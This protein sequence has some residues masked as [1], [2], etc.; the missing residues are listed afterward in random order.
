MGESTDDQN[1]VANLEPAHLAVF[2][3]HVRIKRPG[4]DEPFLTVK[5]QL[6][7]LKLATAPPT[8]CQR[9]RAAADKGL[10]CPTRPKVSVR[11]LLLRQPRGL[12]TKRLISRLVS[13]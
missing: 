8:A 10:P 12:V 9:R 6:S 2:G 1:M 5:V 7:R 11:L 4:E 13:A 3:K